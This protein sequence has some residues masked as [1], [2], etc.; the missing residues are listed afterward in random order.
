MT[1]PERAAV[2]RP[3]R[4]THGIPGDI[5]GCAAETIAVHGTSPPHVIADRIPPLPARVTLC[6]VRGCDAAPQV[7]PALGPTATITRS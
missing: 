5:S 6:S 3:R 4:T 2:P 7:P 1:G